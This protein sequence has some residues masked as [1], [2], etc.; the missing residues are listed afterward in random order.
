MSTERPKRSYRL[1]PDGLASLRTSIARAKPWMSS[2]GPRTP[3][4][5][6]RSR[7]NAWKHGRRSAEEIARRRELAALLR[8]VRGIIVRERAEIRLSKERKAKAQ[9]AWGHVRLVWEWAED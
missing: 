8:E 9:A 6:A 5:K 4:G 2:T 1:T 7:R 3:D